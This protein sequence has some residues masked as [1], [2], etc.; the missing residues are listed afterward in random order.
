MVK[1]ALAKNAASVILVHNHPSGI[2]EPSQADQDLTQKLKA[3]L[4]TIDVRVLDH[5]IV[6]EEILSFSE[7]GLI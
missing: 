5:L 1:R 7:R 3:A 6:G 4:G 2:A